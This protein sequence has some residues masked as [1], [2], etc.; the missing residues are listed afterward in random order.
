[1]KLEED[2]TCWK[3]CGK[4]ECGNVGCCHHVQCILQCAVSLKPIIKYK[5]KIHVS[6]FIVITNTEPQMTIIEN[7]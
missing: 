6:P 3:R 2:H 4:V 7:A 1:M 5:N